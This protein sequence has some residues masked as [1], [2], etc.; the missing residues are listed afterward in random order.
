MKIC[1]L[2]SQTKRIGKIKIKYAAGRTRA[3]KLQS[4]ARTIGLPTLRRRRR[5]ERHSCGR[6]S[7]TERELPT[8]TSKPLKLTCSRTHQMTS[9]APERRQGLNNVDNLLASFS[10]PAKADVRVV[11]R[12]LTSPNASILRGRTDVGQFH[13]LTPCPNNAPL[14]GNDC[15]EQQ[16][17]IRIAAMKRGRCPPFR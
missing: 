7:A 3:R 10:Q 14:R 6:K 12:L 15:L 5:Q 1:P 9:A 17:R 11:C 16:I 13:F 8:T 4:V 2:V